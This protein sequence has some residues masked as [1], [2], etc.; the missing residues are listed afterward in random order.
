VFGS[1]VWERPAC[2]RIIGSVKGNG[3]EE[4]VMQQQTRDTIVAEEGRA[5]W[6]LGELV[7]Y[8]V[9][10][11]D[12]GG[13][14]SLF[15][16]VVQPQGGPPPHIQHRE[17][18]WTYVLEGEFELLNK[19]RTISCGQGSLVY[20]PKGNLH[21]YKNAGQEPGRLLVGQTPGGALQAFFEEVGEEAFDKSAPPVMDG[22]PNVARIVEIAASHGI[23]I[24][25]PPEA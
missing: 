2:E 23:E 16:V 22:P 1:C 17:D 14:F 5:L 6:V 9:A 8:R 11:E 10:S 25:P 24:P 19:G 12:S 21:T 18:E 13:A 4:K 7:T 20:V 3:R 15:E